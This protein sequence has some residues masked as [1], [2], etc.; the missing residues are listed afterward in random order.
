M[1]IPQVFYSQ[2]IVYAFDTVANLT[3]AQVYGDSFVQMAQVLFPA[4]CARKRYPR[5]MGAHTLLSAS[6][7]FP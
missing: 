2:T 6:E 1:N 3:V 7:C 4:H 5:K